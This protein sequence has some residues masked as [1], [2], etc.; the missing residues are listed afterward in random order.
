MPTLHTKTLTVTIDA[1]FEQ[2]AKYLADPANAHEWATEF[3]AAPLRPTSNGEWIASVPVMGGETRYRQD[4][5]LEHG[6]IDVFLAPTDGE[7]GPPLP[8]RLLRN[9]DGTDVLWTLAR[10]PGTP[11]QAWSAGVESM[12]RELDHLK[13][14]LEP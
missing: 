11:D 8:V 4:V 3:F 14:L 1:P 9:G 13:T 6:L 5:D 12:Q 2:V 10:M 7:F